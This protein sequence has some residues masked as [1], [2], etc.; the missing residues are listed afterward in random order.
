M[1]VVIVVVFAAAAGIV[2]VAVAAVVSEREIGPVLTTMRFK[3]TLSSHH[4]IPI[5]TT[6]SQT[7]LPHDN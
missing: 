6:L 1:V 4:T 5:G 7:H 2:V 3:F